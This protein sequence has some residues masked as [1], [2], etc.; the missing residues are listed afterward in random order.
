MEFNSV[1]RKRRSVR[2]FLPGQM[3]EPELDEILLAGISAPIGSNLYKDIHITVVQDKDIMLK[4]S[5]ANDARMKDSKIA[6]EIMGYYAS[7]EK[8]KPAPLPFFG[9]PTVIVVSHRAQT[10]QP[11]I[12]YAN[13]TSVVQTMHLAATSLGIGSV[14]IWGIFE[15]MRLNPKLDYT[16][17]LKLPGNFSPLMGLVVGYPAKPLNEQEIKPDRIPVNYI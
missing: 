17:L 11:G 10:L 14:Y 12:E 8:E 6:E 3:T 2:K 5:L 7:G 4:M 1:L 13:V 15:A 16:G 9:A